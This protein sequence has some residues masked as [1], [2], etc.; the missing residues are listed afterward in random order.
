MKIDTDLL[1]PCHTTI[2]LPVIESMIE[3]F[4]KWVENVII[5][6]EPEDSGNY[7]TTAPSF[8]YHRTAIF[9]SPE[10]I[11]DTE[12]RLTAVIAH[13]IAH[14]YNEPLIRAVNEYLPQLS[15]SEDVLRV[16]NKVFMDS[17]ESQTEELAILFCRED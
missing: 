9:L 6:Y 16:V 8:P 14:C 2:V 7:A 17:I 10:I 5:S 3:L 11:G 15:V 4:P 13:E 1:K 12:E